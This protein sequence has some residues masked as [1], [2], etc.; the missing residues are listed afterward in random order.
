MLSRMY[1]DLEVVV[2]EFRS[3]SQEVPAARRCQRE[4]QRWEGRRSWE[5]KIL[6]NASNRRVTLRADGPAEG[7]DS[8]ETNIAVVV[9]T[10]DAMVE[11]ETRLKLVIGTWRES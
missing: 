9:L 1:E 8:K 10:T 2:E 4:R 7:D 11:G 6:G 5:R 3:W